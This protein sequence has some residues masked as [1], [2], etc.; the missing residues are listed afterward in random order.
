MAYLYWWE[1]IC[2][3]LASISIGIA[4]WK[5]HQNM[6]IAQRDD[7]GKILSLT[8]TRLLA[9][10]FIACGNGHILDPF[11]ML[12]LVTL[13]QQ[14]VGEAICEAIRDDRPWWIS[15]IIWFWILKVVRTS[16]T[17]WN[18]AYKLELKV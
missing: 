2:F 11:I 6:W 10:F 9:R 17:S 4:Y 7:Q 13:H 3:F 12:T 16:I 18:A 15:C 8:N 1:W 5:M 14:L